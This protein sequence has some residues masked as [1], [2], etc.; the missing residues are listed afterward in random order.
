MLWHQQTTL[1]IVLFDF[2]KVSK[3]FQ[4][5][6]IVEALNK[7][8]IDHRYSNDIKNTYKRSRTTINQKKTEPSQIRQLRRTWEADSRSD[9][10]KVGLKMNLEKTKMM[11]NLVPNQLLIVDET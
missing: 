9:P 5:N 6:A 4:L 2:H 1:V 3:T 8:G 10:Q 11:T 7:F